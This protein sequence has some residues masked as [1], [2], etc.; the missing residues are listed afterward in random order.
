MTKILYHANCIDGFGAAYIAKLARP[1]AELIPVRH[2]QPPPDVTGSEVYMVDFMY[3]KREQNQQ[4]ADQS[5]V[6]TILDHHKPN[7]EQAPLPDVGVLDDTRSGTGITWD[8]FFPSKPRPH[9]VDWTED[10]DLWKFKL[11]GTRE[12][13]AYAT[14]VP[15][16]IEGWHD[17]TH[18]SLTSVALAGKAIMRSMQQ[19]VEAC[20]E[21]GYMNHMHKFNVSWV[22]C[23]AH[24]GWGVSELGHY[25]LERFPEAQ[26]SEVYCDGADGKTQH[27]LR[28]RSAEEC[29]VAHIA[30]ARGGGGHPCA[31]GYVSK[32]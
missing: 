8:F 30:K 24:I 27:S 29:N 9:W 14:S 5:I 10:R 11:E 15:M 31:A 7:F 12:F 6:L 20:A 1:D 22:S 2:D 19:Y 13:H 26:Y 21:R 25:L 3:N 23:N 16:T 28:S 4:V 32:A 18:T 17:L